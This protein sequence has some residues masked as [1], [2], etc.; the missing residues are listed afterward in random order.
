M[1]SARCLSGLEQIVAAALADHATD[2]QRALVQPLSMTATLGVVEAIG[3][4]DQ[5]TQINN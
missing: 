4:C 3:C 1:H 5:E 2:T